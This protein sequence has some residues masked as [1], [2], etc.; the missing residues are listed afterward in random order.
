MSH[1]KFIL[2]KNKLGRRV[3]P[4]KNTAEH[5]SVMGRQAGEYGFAENTFTE[6][7]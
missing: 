1:L 2:K 5:P 3:L 4:E 7:F 6:L